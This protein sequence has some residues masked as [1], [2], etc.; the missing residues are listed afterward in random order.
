MKSLASS[1]KFLE[2]RDLGFEIL[3]KLGERLPREIC[4][5][6]V[7]QDMHTIIATLQSTTNEAIMDLKMSHQDHRNVVVLGIYNFLSHVLTEINPRLVPD[8]TIRMMQI[9][10]NDG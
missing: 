10:L 8:I 9:T 1:G 6:M 4:N 2:S 5:P 3:I 7:L